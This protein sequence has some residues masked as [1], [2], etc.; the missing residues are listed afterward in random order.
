ME[1]YLTPVHFEFNIDNSS[2]LF[3]CD[4]MVGNYTLAIT[5]ESR[6]SISYNITACEDI[7]TFIESENTCTGLEV[8]TN[9]GFT[10]LADSAFLAL[11]QADSNE[12]LKW[13]QD[14]NRELCMFLYDL[15][16]IFCEQAE[17]N[18]YHDADGFLVQ[19]KDEIEQFLNQYL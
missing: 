7:E 8:G 3:P 12:N 10:N 14:A 13:F 18:E 9:Y 6:V 4:F 5:I 2:S 16:T 19:F 17:L 11:L 15:E 1:N